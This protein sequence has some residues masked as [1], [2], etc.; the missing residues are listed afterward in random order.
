ML[1]KRSPAKAPLEQMNVS[2]YRY[3]DRP[4]PMVECT[5][6]GLSQEAFDRD[7]NPKPAS[8]MWV[9]AITRVYALNRPLPTQ[10]DCTN[11]TN[12][13]G[14][15]PAHAVETASDVDRKVDSER[16]L[17]REKVLDSTPHN[18]ENPA[19]TVVGDSASSKM[20]W[21]QSQREQAFI[22]WPR[23]TK[24]FYVF[25]ACAEFTMSRAL[26][27]PDVPKWLL[28]FRFTQGFVGTCS[29]TNITEFYARVGEN[30][31]RLLWKNT[32]QLVIVDKKTRKPTR[33]PKWFIDKY[34]GWGSLQKG[35]AFRPFKR[36][37]LTYCHPIQVQW[38]DTDEY[39]HANWSSYMKWATDA[40]HAA[41]M[42]DKNVKSS[43]GDSGRQTATAT[44]THCNNDKTPLTTSPEQAENPGKMARGAVALC[45]INEE[46]MRQGLAKFQVS[47]YRECLEGDQVE[48]HVW[49]DGSDGDPGLVYCCLVKDREEICQVKM[50]Y[51]TE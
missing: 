6:P 9:D 14:G 40:L 42:L 34:Q 18:V 4:Y 2:N 8:L 22:N 12:Q 24:E 28:D 47:F 21:T 29:V 31:K 3:T 1:T 49:Q 35:L 26:Y 30:E 27:D 23:I 50:W 10:D 38:S 48:A 32:Y 13:G 19:D 16:G 41:L 5:V 46:T 20:F 45:G 11:I 7:W 15:A 44:S 43:S 17:E 36:P 37:R 33:T 51:F 25:G 39:R